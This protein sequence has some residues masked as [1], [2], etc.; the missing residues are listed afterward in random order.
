MLTFIKHKHIKAQSYKIKTTLK[1][2][3]NKIAVNTN[4]FYKERFRKYFDVCAQYK[5]MLLSATRKSKCRTVHNSARNNIANNLEF[6]QT[7]PRSLL[8]SRQP[9]RFHLFILLQIYRAAAKT[10]ALTDTAERG[11]G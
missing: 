1:K 6:V 9:V 8:Q 7:I 5:T 10:P 11:D 4:V 2:Y 3:F